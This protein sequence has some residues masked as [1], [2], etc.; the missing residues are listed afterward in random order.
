[1]G[2]EDCRPDLNGND[3]LAA[4]MGSTIALVMV[5]SRGNSRQDCLPM[6]HSVVLRIATVDFPESPN[7]RTDLDGCALH[8][9]ALM[10]GPT[11]HVYPMKRQVVHDQAHKRIL[12]VLG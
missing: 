5:H 3:T 1:M 11:V 8:L 6:S 4:M 10:N 2:M 7:G 9:M 12:T